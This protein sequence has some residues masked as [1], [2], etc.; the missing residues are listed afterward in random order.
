MVMIR[1]RAA[2]VAS[3]VVLGASILVA[4]L[5]AK[6]VRA[7]DTNPLTELIDAAAQRLQVAEPVAALKWKTHGAI[8]DPGR[9]RQELAKMRADATANHIDP[10]YVARIF[11]DQI[12]ATEAIEYRR[13]ADWKLNSAG[14]PATAPDLSASRAAI[15][16]YNQ[17][18]LTQIAADWVLLHS[19]G[20]AALL[21]EARSDVVRAR[22]F[23][24]LYQQA[25][26]SAT[27]SYCA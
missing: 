14:A 4:M 16:T 3:A 18:M 23:D 5:A 19:P 17:T 21:D 13:F 11:G 6:P 9:V 27:Q 2:R 12:D 26:S 10:D 7:D 15:D 22:Q 24:A 1:S 20:C 25:L 8:D